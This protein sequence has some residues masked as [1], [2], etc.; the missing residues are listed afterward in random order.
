MTY[1]ASPAARVVVEPG[2]VPVGDFRQR[3]EVA[4]ARVLVDTHVAHRV[5]CG[6]ARQY[7]R[8]VDVLP[9]PDF[10]SG[11]TGAAALTLF[12]R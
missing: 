5:E 3:F 1:P 7:A 8:R 11:H 12:V 9:C 10:S 4:G 6:S 2:H